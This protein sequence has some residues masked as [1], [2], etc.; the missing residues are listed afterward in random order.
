MV[1]IKISLSARTNEIVQDLADELGIKKSELVK[2]LVIDNLKK[3]R[4]KGR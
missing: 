1:E 3:S 4:G 2:N